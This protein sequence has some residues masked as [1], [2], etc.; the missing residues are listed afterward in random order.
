MCGTA[1]D[2]CH[3]AVHV[4]ADETRSPHTGHLF[5]LGE[6]RTELHQFSH[7]FADMI[8]SYSNSLCDFFAGQHDLAGVWEEV[9]E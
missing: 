2:L 3:M 9:I 5:A 1:T 7:N 8:G 4:V 6:N